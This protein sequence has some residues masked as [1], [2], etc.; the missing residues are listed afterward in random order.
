VEEAGAL[1]G[2]RED[3]L[4]RNLPLV[5]RV[6]HRLAARKPPHINSTIVSWASSAC[7]TRSPHDPKKEASFATHPAPHPRD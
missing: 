3:I 7:S 5:R 4:L 2:S 1:A 6:V